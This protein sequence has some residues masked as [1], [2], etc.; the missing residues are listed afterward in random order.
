MLGTIPGLCPVYESNWSDG[1]SKN[2]L[3]FL[4]A[5]AQR[6]PSRPALVMPDGATI[7]FGELWQRVCRVSNGLQHEGLRSGDR[8]VVMIPMSIDLYSVMLGIIKM[9]AVAVFVDP[10]MSMQKIAR[11]AA[12]ADPSGFAGVGRSHLLRLLDGSLRGLPL[13]IST[14]R[15]IGRFPA[16]L[17]MDDLLA[18]EP[19]MTIWEPPSPDAPALITF[20][21]GSSGVPKGANRT[22]RFLAAQYGAL[23][24]E[25]RY[26]DTDVDM[27]MFP[28]FALRNLADGIPSVI[29][30]M[31]FRRV[32]DVN[33]HKLLTQIERHGVT[34]CTAS[35]PFVQRLVDALRQSQ[36]RNPLRRILT[37]GAPVSDALLREWQSVVPETEITVVYGSTEAEPVAS[38]SL[39]DRLSVQGKGYCTGKPIAAIKAR[40]IPIVKG[41]VTFQSWRELEVPTGT[42]GELIVSGEHV[43]RDYFRNTDAVK[44]NKLIDGDGSC[45]HRMGDTGYFDP[46]GRFWLT[47]RVHSTL[48][49]GGKVLHA[50]LVESQVAGLVPDADRVAALEHSGQLVVVV[51]GRYHAELDQRIASLGLPPCKVLFTTRPLP[52]DP[53]H[54]SKIDYD[55]L[56]KWVIKRL[57]KGHAR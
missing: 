3:S 44:A 32:S 9:G 52:L 21:S 43:C 25:Y 23:A 54:Q 28:V 22:H 57:D 56:R 53:R 14:G 55:A 46:D 35:P 15:R 40:L 18:Y 8:M 38:M 30:E 17:T 2:I 41:P 49:C 50:Q 47:G 27:P 6:A 45:W 4:Q 39:Q 10:W 13:T 11:F 16:R 26:A 42:V 1:M 5:V 29:P 33:G 7:T 34:T 48:Y 36:T 20:T 24:A 51:Q 31:D 19:D 12:F 37:G